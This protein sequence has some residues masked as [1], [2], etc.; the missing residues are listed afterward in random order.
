MFQAAGTNG[1]SFVLTPLRLASEV[2][3]VQLHLAP[4]MPPLI[5]SSDFTPGGGL[6][7]SAGKYWISTRSTRFESGL[8]LVRLIAIGWVGCLPSGSFNWLR[9]PADCHSS[10]V[11]AATSSSVEGFLPPFLSMA[12]ST[13]VFSPR[14]DCDM[15]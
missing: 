8:Y 5:Q 14:I 11:I 7:H 4:C 9:P 2:C 10:P 6:T 12:F 13:A 3:L 15:R 1:A